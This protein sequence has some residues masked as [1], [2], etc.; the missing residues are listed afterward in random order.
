MVVSGQINKLKKFLISVLVMFSFSTCLAKQNNKIPLI[1]QQSKTE[2]K[3]ILII[4]ID[5]HTIDYTNPEIPQGLTA[6]KVEQGT[7]A[8][9]AMLKE[10]GYEADIFLIKTGNTDLSD[11]A[12]YLQHQK[13]DGIVIGNGIR[14]LKSNFILFEKIVNEVHTSAPDSKIIFNSLPTDTIESVKRWM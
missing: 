9:I 4:G 2:M 1:E 5:P 6:E 12:S 11:L 7:K 10:N 3:R 13:Y 14:G 8:T